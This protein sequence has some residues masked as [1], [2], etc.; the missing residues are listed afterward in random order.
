MLVL[1]Q[2]MMIYECC[3]GCR[4]LLMFVSRA[5][6]LQS[7][8]V[9]LFHTL[10][11]LSRLFSHYLCHVIRKKDKRKLIEMKKENKTGRQRRAEAMSSGRIRM[12]V[13]PPL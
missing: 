8:F 7:L 2:Q 5:I 10:R 3:F 1:L 13:V 12:C 9:A 6:A 4:G 11:L